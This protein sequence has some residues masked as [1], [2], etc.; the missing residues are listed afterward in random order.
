MLI[1]QDHAIPVDYSIS[2]P[3]APKTAAGASKKLKYEP[4]TEQRA[5]ELFQT[6][7]DEED[8]D[9]IGLEGFEKLCKDAD[10]PLDGARPIIFSWQMQA[11]EMGKITKD[12]WVQ[13]MATLKS[14]LMSFVASTGSINFPFLGLRIGSIAGLS[15]A[16]E[17]LDDLL[18]NDK[19]SKATGKEYDRTT[20]KTYASNPKAA[21]Q[22][23]YMFSF[24]LVKPEYAS[25]FLGNKVPSY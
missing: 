4:Y 20:Y 12:E 22:K 16:I 25:S 3:Q 23:L 11:E 17:E 5:F 13:G 10:M 18:F 6:Y 21:F 9:L 19:K 1:C 24:S 14:V 8:K 7:A 2:T 15:L